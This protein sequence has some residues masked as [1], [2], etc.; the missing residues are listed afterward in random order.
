MAGD[1]LIIETARRLTACL[2][3]TDMVARLS[4]DDPPRRPPGNDIIARLGGDEFTILLDSIHDVSDPI[5][6]AERIQRELA[7]AFTLEGQTVCTTASIGIALSTTGYSVVHDILRDADIAMYRAKTLGKA[8]C[9]VFDQAMHTR[10]VTRLQLEAELRHAVECQQFGVHYQPIVSL[11]TG[12]I[13]G[14]EALVRWEHPTKGLVMPS[15]FIPVAEETGLILSIGKQVLLE[16]CRQ[17]RIWQQHFPQ[18]PPLTMSVNFSAKQLAQPILLDQ[19]AHVL[20]ETGVAPNSLGVELTESMAMENA[21]RTRPLL[22][23]LKRLN[24]RS[25]IDDFGTGYSSLNYLRRLPIDILKI[26][27]SFV[28]RV[29]QDDDN[30]EIVRTIMMLA[31]NLGMGVIAEGVEARGEIEHLKSLKCEHAQGYFFARP[32]DRAGAEII[33]QT[34]PW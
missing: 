26:D 21:E 9:E 14:F 27:R 25:C 22:L 3:R 31:H 12:K 10:A 7:V 23:E 30:R 13:S 1:L 5:R 17:A 34:R 19:I 24:V 11:L 33:L 15:E 32:L 20:Q 18:D 28:S 4:D 8:R 6:V 16:A 29:D 2:R